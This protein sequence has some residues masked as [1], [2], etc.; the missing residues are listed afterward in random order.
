M[1][2]YLLLSLLLVSCSA[3]N[4]YVITRPLENG[5]TMIEVHYGKY[6]YLYQADGQRRLTEG[7][8]IEH[9]V[10]VKDYVEQ[11]E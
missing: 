5:N 1:T 10:A 9:L 7:E 3:S 6:V 4:Q 11:V 8:K 2:R